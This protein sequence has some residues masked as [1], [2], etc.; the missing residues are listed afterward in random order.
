MDGWKQ[1]SHW[2]AC[3]ARGENKNIDIERF[4]PT[5]N[6]WLAVGKG[7]WNF[8]PDYKY[9]IK[10]PDPARLLGRTIWTKDET[11]SQEL[12]DYYKG[13]YRLKAHM[14]GE[15]RVNDW[16]TADQLEKEFDVRG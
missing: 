16:L 3:K 5:I 14:W 6:D 13:T 10:T 12:G 1:V 15:N 7:S 11:K 8:H 2:E 9:R 4:F